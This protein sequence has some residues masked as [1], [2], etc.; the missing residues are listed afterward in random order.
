M[1]VRNGNE[2]LN[3]ISENKNKQDCNWSLQSCLRLFLVR[4]S[5]SFL[6]Q[7]CSYLNHLTSN[8]DG[9]LCRSLGI[10]I[11]ANGGGHNV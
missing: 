10:D 8:G 11:Y 7:L 4:G 1:M 2:E 3:F 5:K 6:I 9:N